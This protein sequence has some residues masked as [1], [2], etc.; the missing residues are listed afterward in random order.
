MVRLVNQVAYAF[1]QAEVMAPFRDFLKRNPNNMQ[2]WD[3]TMDELFERSKAEIVHLIQEGVKAFEKNRPTCLATD[4][5]R[6]GMGFTLTQKHCNCKIITPE[7]GNGHWK[8]VLMGSR[9]AKEAESRYAPIEGEA[10]AVVYGL[11]CCK[12]FV[13]GHP[14]LIITVDHKPLI[15]ILNN[16]SMDSIENPR[17]LRIKEKTLLY[18]YD[19]IHVPGKSNAAPDAASRYPTHLGDD[20][21]DDDGS[22]AFA[23]QQKPLP[24]LSTQQVEEAPTGM[25]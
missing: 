16:R 17:L 20:E 22:R 10:L 4:W 2:F 13:L 7:C 5:S 19:I 21:T 24:G 3:E 8:I 25:P 11:Q 12:M 6:T 14:S 9:F 15:K 1:A 23:I 18:Q